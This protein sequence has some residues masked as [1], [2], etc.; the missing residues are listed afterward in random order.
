ME[1]EKVTER[2][3]G[4]YDE[5]AD[6]AFLLWKETEKSRILQTP[7]F[8]VNRVVRESTDGRKGPFVEIRTP[9]W[10]NIVPVFTG[11]DGEKYFV[12]ERQFRHGGASVVLEFPAGLVEEG[13]KSEDAALRELWEE[14]GI[15]AGRIETAGQVNPNPALMATA[16]TVFIAED[17]TFTGKRNL[18]A[19]EQIE[20]VC[21]KVAVLF[22]I[23]GKLKQ[24]SGMTYINA[25]M[26]LKKRGKICLT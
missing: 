1:D 14:T 10:V 18:D 4:L 8:D 6:E 26:Y 22:D 19:N 5:N 24:N 13:E 9:R 3:F 21:I 17:L 12:M 25:F 2:T 7:V 15:R 20:V 11:T 23:I 16:G